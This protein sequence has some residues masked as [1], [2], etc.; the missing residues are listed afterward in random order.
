MCLPVFPLLILTCQFRL[1]SLSVSP[2]MMHSYMGWFN[3]ITLICGT[4]HL[5]ATMQISVFPSVQI[6][7]LLMTSCSCGKITETDVSYSWG[8]CVTVALRDRIKIVWCIYA[9]TPIFPPK[10][11]SERFDDLFL[12]LFW[13][14]DASHLEDE[15]TLHM[16]M[17]L[18]IWV[19]VMPHAYAQEEQCFF[20]EREIV[21]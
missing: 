19:T 17:C 20:S 21:L 8:L 7:W 11:H 18:F 3:I 12:F 14:L 5:A 4:S 16:C 1:G 13:H 10:C 6:I 15:S 9:T 2:H